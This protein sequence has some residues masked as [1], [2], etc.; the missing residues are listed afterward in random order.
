VEELV[1]LLFWLGNFIEENENI[2]ADQ[3][4]VNPRGDAY[5]VIVI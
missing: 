4:P 1:E 2:H 5:W 3:S